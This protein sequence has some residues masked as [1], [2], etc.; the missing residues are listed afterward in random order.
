MAALK[1]EIGKRKETE[2]NY[3]A[4]NH[5]A[6]RAGMMRRTY[7]RRRGHRRSSSL[8][9]PCIKAAVLNLAL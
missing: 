8:A 6:R 9:Q 7:R 5:M 4:G 3:K 1:L 2:T